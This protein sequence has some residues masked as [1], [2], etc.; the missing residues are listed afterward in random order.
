[1]KFYLHLSLT[2]MMG[3]NTKTTIGKSNILIA[4]FHIYFCQGNTRKY[5]LFYTL[6]IKEMCIDTMLSVKPIYFIYCSIKLWRMK[7]KTSA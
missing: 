1:M 6:D 3:M 2:E 4:L 5:I 7:F